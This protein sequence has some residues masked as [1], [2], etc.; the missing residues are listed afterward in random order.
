MMKIYNIRHNFGSGKWV[1]LPEAQNFIDTLKSRLEPAGFIY[2]IRLTPRHHSVYIKIGNVR[3]AKWYMEKY[4]R[5][6]VRC[7]IHNTYDASGMNRIA[8]KIKYI[9][10]PHPTDD[11]WHFLRIVLNN[12]LNNFGW[13]ATVHANGSIVVRKGNNAY[14]VFKGNQRSTTICPNTPSYQIVRNHFWIYV[15]IETEPYASPRKY[16]NGRGR[17]GWIQ[18]KCIAV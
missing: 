17:R 2:N 1:T 13:G 5:K 7:E 10:S 9:T 6:V 16:E 18:D 3:M 14:D 12:T 8:T 15:V 11:D 4:G